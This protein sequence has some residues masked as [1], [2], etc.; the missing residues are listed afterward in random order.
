MLAR[1]IQT[2]LHTFTDVGDVHAQK[3]HLEPD[4]R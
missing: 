1:C 2:Q 3:K 4:S